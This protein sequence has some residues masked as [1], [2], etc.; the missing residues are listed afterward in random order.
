MVFDEDLHGN[1]HIPLYF[2]RKLY[3]EFTMGK[4]VNYFDIL[5]FQGVGGG[6]PQ[7]RE[8]AQVDPNLVCPSLFHQNPPWLYPLACSLIVET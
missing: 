2:L 3:V 4:D 8:H 1:H 6:M 7:H 5:E